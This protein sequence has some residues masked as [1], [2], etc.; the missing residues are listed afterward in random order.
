MREGDQLLSPSFILGRIDCCLEG[1]QL[2][3]P[4]F[5]I[6]GGMDCCLLI[7][8]TGLACLLLPCFAAPLIWYAAHDKML[9]FQ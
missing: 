1:D 9:Y 5:F 4:S 6:L 3:S 7:K 8:L 2:L